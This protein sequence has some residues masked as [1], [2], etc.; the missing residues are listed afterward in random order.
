MPT[1]ST[2]IT[3]STSRTLGLVAIASGENYER[4]NQTLEAAGFSRLSNGAYAASLA[5][6]QA[7]RHTASALVHR[8]HEHG[9]TLVTSSRPYLGDVGIEIAARLPGTWNAE[10][11][12]Y[13]HPL[14][15]DDLWYGLW[16]A[17][18]IH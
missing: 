17:G 1:P 3:L 7:A 6:A 16:E 2:E 18:E 10:V 8:A 4:A 12:I 13:A 9:A 11:E 5:D 14:W 15:Q